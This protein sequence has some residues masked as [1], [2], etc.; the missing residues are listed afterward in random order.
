MEDTKVEPPR[1]IDNVLQL[2]G[3]LGRY[4]LFQAVLLAVGNLSICFHLL[5]FV[6]IGKFSSLFINITVSTFET[7][8]MIP[9]NIYINE[10]EALCENNFYPYHKIG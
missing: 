8:H 1:T 7:I 10:S 5:N 4:Q 6:F 3:S 2:L 9:D